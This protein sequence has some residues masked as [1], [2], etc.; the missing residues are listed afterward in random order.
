MTKSSAARVAS[1]AIAPVKAAAN[2]ARGEV[3]ITVRGRTY[4]AALSLGAIAEIEDAFS[5]DRLSKLG[6]VL[7]D[8]GSR[9]IATVLAA[10]ING[11]EGEGT[12]TVDEIR[13][14][15]VSI[16]AAKQTISDAIQAAGGETEEAA[17]AAGK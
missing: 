7:V 10:L 11:G 6:A 12:V 14:W 1:R 2:R 16:S 17:A 15:P 8:P 4:R 13:K 3:T 9:D 5:I